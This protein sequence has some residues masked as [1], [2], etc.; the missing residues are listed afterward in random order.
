MPRTFQ[1]R[2][3][4][5][6]SPEENDHSSASKPDKSRQCG[7]HLD[8]RLTV[9]TPSEVTAARCQR[10]LIFKVKVR[11]HDQLVAAH[12]NASAW[13]PQITG[14][15]KELVVRAVGNPACRASTRSTTRI[16]SEPVPTVWAPRTLRA[17]NRKLGPACLD[18]KCCSRSPRQ[19]SAAASSQGSSCTVRTSLAV[20]TSSSGQR[21]RATKVRAEEKKARK[22]WQKQRHSAKGIP[23]E[24]GI[25]MGH[26][27]DE[28]LAGS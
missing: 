3:A 9:N 16:T 21:G 26:V 22:A 25:D 11:N 17:S 6:V 28:H 5:V 24:A 12:P 10:I 1:E 20:S 18:R 7:I 14:H 23:M 13:A 4:L 27:R 8:V 15:R 19:R 2:L